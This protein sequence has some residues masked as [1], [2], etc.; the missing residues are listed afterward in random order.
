MKKHKE[1][2]P[3][4]LALHHYGQQ[5]RMEPLAA[6]VSF[7]LPG[8]GTIL[9]F[10]VPP[11]IIARILATF[12]NKPAVA[13][14]EFV[15]YILLF[16]GVWALGEFLWRIAVHYIIKI[17]INGMSRLY[18]Q[19]TAI[20]LKKDLSFFDNNF[21]G[22]L[23]KK[24]IGYARNF[25]GFIDTLAFSV[26]SQVIPLIFVC[27]VL[28]SFSPWLF[29]GLLGSIALTVMCVTPLIMRRQKLVDVREAASNVLSGNV[30][31]TIGNMAAVRTFAQEEFEAENNQKYVKD[32][33]TK[34][35]VTWM[36]Q[37]LRI[38]VATSPLYVGA[39]VLGLALALWLSQQG[40]FNIE[41]V[42]V[43]F[44]YY[45][46]VTRVMWEFNN[47]YRGL[48]SSITEAAQFTELIQYE[49]L[50]KDDPEAAPFDLKTPSVAL[51][52]VD[53][54]YN[55]NRG[56]H[57]FK[58]LELNIKPGEKIGLVG[59]SGGGK[60][61]IAK[62]LLR[63]MDVAGGEITVDGRD[64]RTIRQQ[65]LRR[66]ISYVPQD[67]LLFHRSLS[68]NISY[69]KLDANQEEIEH[70]AKLAYADEFIDKL[71]EGYKTM[72]GERG[73][74]LS[75]G[76]RQRV[77]IARAIL[78]DSPILVLDEATSALDSESESLIQDAL[79]NLMKGRTTIVIAH[80]LSTIQKMDRI[81]VL[82]EGVITEQGSHAELLEK[83]GLY[84]KLWGH[85]S[86]GFLED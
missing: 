79:T 82:E 73:V 51:R 16:A 83:K 7:L 84:A 22:S 59:P 1:L 21:A 36:Y 66:Y 35:K 8:I 29:V 2:T 33:M 30:S 18:Q 38:D 34:A 13:F 24:A 74:K 54:K 57:L 20:L 58:N 68:E 9:V 75:G 37:N 49:P 40:K 41:V 26:V 39:N 63:V 31:D 6:I 28:W 56:E 14:S 47:I 72:V 55:D 53:F 69:G 78:K 50:I 81:I 44:S 77:S 86:G 67:P 48:E 65:D 19:A 5:I 61:T 52:H 32:Y 43:A 62:L 11:L 85:Q 64:I 4:R 80:R 70:A 17:E 10:Y 3:T 76:Q 60:T 45:A 12:G 27:I 46:G 25:E 71:S 42:F 23:T 15:P